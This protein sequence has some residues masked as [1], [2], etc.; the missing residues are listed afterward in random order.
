MY[1]GVLV[2]CARLMGEQELHP[3]GS[4]FQGVE[5]CHPGLTLQASCSL[6][7]FQESVI[8]A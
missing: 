7:I 4:G 2:V 5:G 3:Q 8:G 6:L 1:G